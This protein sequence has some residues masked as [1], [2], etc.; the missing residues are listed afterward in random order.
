M[1]PTLGEFE[2][3]IL[4]AIL[5]LPEDAY[6]PAIRAEIEHRAKRPVARGAVY[7]TLDRLETKGL[8]GSKLANDPDASRSRRY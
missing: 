4:L 3:L 1:P 6:A 2:A 7:V 8:L 5:H